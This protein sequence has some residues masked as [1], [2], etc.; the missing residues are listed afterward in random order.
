MHINIHL[1]AVLFVMVA[2]LLSLILILYLLCRLLHDICLLWRLVHCDRVCRLRNRHIRM[3]LLACLL[4]QRYG[5][6]WRVGWVLLSNR[7][8]LNCL[9]ELLLLSVLKIG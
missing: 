2:T 7:M 6:V 8:I 3:A 5:Y 4:W 1:F 9:L